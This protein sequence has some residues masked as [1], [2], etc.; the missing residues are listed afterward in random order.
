M[1]DSAQ[2]DNEDVNPPKESIVLRR[3]RLEHLPEIRVS[4]TLFHHVFKAGCSMVNCNAL[5]C[6]GGVYVDVKERDTILAH[7][8]MVRRHMEDVQQHDPDHWFESEEI[9][10]ADFPSGRSVG[11]QA[12]ADGCV[13]LKRDGKCVLQSASLAEGMGPYALKPFFCIAYPITID[14]GEL[15]ID[16]PTY[17]HRA[18]CCSAVE[19]GPLSAFDV[20]MEELEFTL[21]SAGVQE[22]EEHAA[23][24]F[25]QDQIQ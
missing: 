9:I 6:K 22:L 17:T 13:F 12:N 24:R 2:N 8:W 5:C 7:A 1:H 14:H 15:M 21:G 20:C 19:D 23:R 25:T 16:D 10:D 11:T 4:D 3:H 18:E